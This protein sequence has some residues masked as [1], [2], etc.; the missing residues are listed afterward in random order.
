MPIECRCGPGKPLSWRELSL[1]GSL[2]TSYGRIRSAFCVGDPPKGSGWRIS[3]RHRSSPG[4]WRAT[5]A[6]SYGVGSASP[7]PKFLPNRSDGSAIE[8]LQGMREHS[9]LL[10]LDMLRVELLQPS[11]LGQ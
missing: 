4:N 1:L 3:R 6:Y 7:S 2:P 10:Y 11:G 8:Q 5:L 9:S